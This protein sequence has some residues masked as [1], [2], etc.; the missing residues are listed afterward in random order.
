[1][2]TLCVSDGRREVAT[3]HALLRDTV[4]DDSRSASHGLVIE[5]QS[6]M[7]W[8]GCSSAY[9][10]DIFGSPLR[11]RGSRHVH[12]GEADLIGLSV[13]GRDQLS[14]GSSRDRV[15]SRLA[16]AWLSTFFVL[17]PTR[18]SSTQS[19]TDRLAY[20]PGGGERHLR[21]SVPEGRV[22]YLGARP[23]RG[24][25]HRRVPRLGVSCWHLLQRRSVEL[26]RE[27]ATLAIMVVSFSS[28]ASAHLRQRV[29]RRRHRRP[30]DEDRRDRGAGTDGHPASFSLF[31][32]GGF[33]VDDQTH[34]V[35]GRSA[36]AC[37]RSL[38]RLVTTARSYG[39]ERASR[40]GT[41][42]VRARQ[43]HPGRSASSIGAC[44]PWPIWDAL[45]LPRVAGAWVRGTSGSR[46]AE[47]PQRV[48]VAWPDRVPVPRELAA[49]GS[50]GTG[51]FEPGWSGALQ[52]KDASVVHRQHVDIRASAW[53]V[54][55]LVHVL[56]LRSTCG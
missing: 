4:P 50:H 42:S 25:V 5:F 55:A 8:S 12:A 28:S 20:R 27:A 16:R 53:C 6:G 36:R 45:L 38:P 3:A 43:L 44:A 32:I 40:P 48:A 7:N 37:S 22:V 54:R 33:T 52:D 35:L 2:Q 31:Q 9:V 24:A 26:F 10:G 39:M 18:G 29:R 46:T 15:L 41:S 1:M 13:F 21:H 23:P 14:R 19:D 17:P 47:W 51:R 34:V 30:A 56:R 11:D 49:G